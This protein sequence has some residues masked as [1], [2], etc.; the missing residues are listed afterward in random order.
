M[1][2]VVKYILVCTILL[3]FV[4]KSYS[5][6]VV[7]GFTT[8]VESSKGVYA[9]VVLKDESGK[10]IA[11]TNTN[12]KGYYELVSPTK[13][14]FYLSVSSLAYEAASKE[15]LI[16]GN[17]AKIQQDFV[18][19]AKV[20][21]LEE[22]VI[23]FKTPTTVKKD[24]II[25][26]AK[27][28]LQ[29]NE[30]VVEDLLKK[31]PGLNVLP[32]GTVK[33]GNQEVEKIMIDGD[34]FFEKGYKVVTKSMPVNPI[35]KVELYQ[36]YSNNKHLKGIENSD[37]VA[38]NLILK[39]DAKNVWF[40]N[41]SGG[42]GV[43]SEYRYDFRGNLMS[44]GKK[45][46]HYFL[47][48]FNNVGYD[49]IGDI[50]NLIR[51]F[52]QGEPSGIGDNQSANAILSLNY[53]LPNLTK[54][55]VNL[56]NSKMLSLNSI[57]TLSKKVKVK[58]LGFL[59]TDENDFFRNSFQSFSLAGSVFNNTEDFTG[60]KAQATGF[61]KVD[62]TYDVS[63]NRTLEYVGKFN[64]TDFKNHS[65]LLFNGNLINERLNSN[66]QLIDQKLTFTNKLTERKVLLL[67]VRYINEK[68]PQNYSVNRFIFSDLFPQ[69]A[70]ESKQY[71]QNQMQFA[72]IEAQLLDKKKNGNLLE[73]KFGNQLRTDNLDSYFETLD[74]NKNSTRYSNGYSNNLTYTTN[75][76]YLLAKNRF[77]FGKY[78]LVTQ[79][80]VHQ[81]FN[82]FKNTDVESSQ[83]PLFI[84]PTIG[85]DWEINKKNKITTSYFYN[86]TN[87]SILDVY[88]GFIQTGFRSFSKG[89]GE[90]NQLNSS[91][92]VLKHTYGNWGDN[93][94]AN[95]AVVY[96]KNNDFYSTNSMIAQNYTISE[97]I[98]IKDRNY[99]SVASNIDY[100]FKSIKTN[101]KINFGG[102]K[103]NF[104]NIVNSSK[105][106]EVENLS[107]DYG[108]EMRSGFGG[109]F[110]CV[111]G[112]KWN[113]N[114]VKTNTESA[115]TT[116]MSFL[117]LSFVFNEKFNL[118]IQSERYFF[119]NLDKENNQYYFLDLEARYTVKGNKFEISVQANNLL[120]TQ[121]FRNYGI[122]DI[123]ISKTE[124]RLQPRYALLS[125]N[126]RF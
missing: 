83:T 14:L 23:A 96:S 118:Q 11:F 112:S 125:L 97:K 124:Y 84:V 16:E 29:G 45:N 17:L 95:T 8:D 56:N 91:N 101:L 62:L 68:T 99:L 36:H 58:T 92:A 73:I 2:K 47:T 115:F 76:L 26:D 57:F 79:I 37:K 98:I 81:L 27:S 66:N 64:K 13:G 80:D 69:S 49:A 116:N 1:G 71:S 82:K 46:K 32:D 39:E 119:G 117:D 22:V 34:D 111:L 53:E 89:L 106:R 15:I 59:N 30:R 55:R 38:L 72:G 123:N 126:Y 103:N 28:F 100:Y 41:V 48:N 109:F 65:D 5:Q 42:Y 51:P 121:T 104:K 108:F 107:I 113:Y 33:I 78:T 75:D 44:F 63:K 122:S 35:D 86:T 102:S 9:S 10:I 67:F 114:Q 43:S 24:T 19:N 20:T 94:F 70:N 52:R 60:K 12:S 61:G 4:T 77:K 3:L 40:G 105:L 7:E 6:Y 31:I 18:L 21:E 74:S 54:Q 50:N 120:N 90:F 85:L 87:A 110:N 88:S 25:F 93:F